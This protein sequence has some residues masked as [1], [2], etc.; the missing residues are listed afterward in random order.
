V[1]IEVS[2]GR[3][4]AS[5]TQHNRM[6]AKDRFWSRTELDEPKKSEQ[7]RTWMGKLRRTPVVKYLAEEE[8]PAQDSRPIL[9]LS[10]LGE[11]KKE[12]AFYE[13]LKPEGEKIPL[14]RSEE[15]HVWVQTNAQFV[16]EV[17]AEVDAIL[18]GSS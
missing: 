7:F 9:R 13:L 10:Y 1:A 12:L 17:M 5:Y 16:D 4:T 15:T 14:V 18:G 6:A 2:S 11:D 3:R 8:Q